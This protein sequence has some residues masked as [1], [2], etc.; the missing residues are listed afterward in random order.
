MANIKLLFSMKLPCTCISKSDGNVLYRS[1]VVEWLYLMYVHYWLEINFRF[2]FRMQCS[3]RHCFP[4]T[5]SRHTPHHNNNIINSAAPKILPNFE[6]ILY[7]SP[8]HFLYFI[9]NPNSKN[10]VNVKTTKPLDAISLLNGLIDTV[11]KIGKEQEA[12]KEKINTQ[13]INMDCSIRVV[14]N[15]TRKLSEELRR[16]SA[17]KGE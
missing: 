11:K 1:Y 3:M 15:S 7:S 13:L 10:V 2:S 6:W 12:I 16:N 5:S 8:G 9:A 14:E 4:L 17:K